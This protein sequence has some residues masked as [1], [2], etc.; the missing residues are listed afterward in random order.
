MRSLLRSS[1]VGM[2]FAVAALVIGIVLALHRYVSVVGQGLGFDNASFLTNGAVFSGFYQY[3]YDTTRPP[4]IPAILASVFLVTGGP[5]VES[6]IIV[7]GIFYAVGVFGT[8]LL[9]KSVVD[10]SLA[11]LSAI[12]FNTIVNVVYWAGSG[13][14]D[15]ESM[16]V[17]SLG[18]GLVVHATQRQRPKEYLIAVPVLLLAFFTRYTMGAVIIAALVYLSLENRNKKLDTEKIYFGF[19]LSIMVAAAVAYKWFGYAGGSISNF[20]PQSHQ[21]AGTLVQT[22]Y[23]TNLVTEL[24]N[25]AY[26]ILLLSLFVGASLLFVHDLFKRKINSVIAALYVWIVLALAYYSLFQIDPPGGNADIL[27]YS[28]E[29]VYP[30]ILLGFWFVHRTVETLWTRTPHLSRRTMWAGM[31]IVAILLVIVSGYASFASGWNENSVPSAGLNA[32]SA[33]Q[34]AAGWLNHNAPTNTTLASP[35]SAGLQWYAPQFRVYWFDGSR[36]LN[37]TFAMQ[38][39]QLAR[40]HVNYLVWSSADGKLPWNNRHLQLAWQSQN[41]WVEIYKIS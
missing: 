38:I 29:F 35:W 32:N 1:K 19:M 31:A 40:A 3:G 37:Q 5:R 28:I 4:L 30:M 11:L 7:S 9:A 6:G 33:M 24:G 22:G 13:Y 26:G 36:Q 10:R 14:S 15:V 18:L 39:G 27:R 21:V 17:A 20:F 2:A 23:V 16:A 8:Y 41:D 25:G 12:S 34:E